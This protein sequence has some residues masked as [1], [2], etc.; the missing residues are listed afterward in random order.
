[1]WKELLQALCL[2]LVLEGITPFLYPRRWRQLA[3]RLA[4]IDDGSL[5]WLGFA[6][7][8]IGVGLLYLSR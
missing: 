3:A 1:M 5:R 4:S 2:V 7:M 6:S 8:V